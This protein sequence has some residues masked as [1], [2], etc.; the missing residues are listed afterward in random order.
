MCYKLKIFD[1]FFSELKSSIQNKAIELETAGVPITEKVI[2]RLLNRFEKIHSEVCDSRLEFIKTQTALAEVKAKDEELDDLGDGYKVIDYENLKTELQTISSNIDSKNEELEKLRMR[3]NSNVE[4]S[5]EYQKNRENFEKKIEHVRKVYDEKKSEEQ[6]MQWELNNLRKQKDLMRHEYEKL[7]QKSQ[8]LI[9]TPLLR[10]YD[11]I[12]DELENIDRE[13]EK[14]EGKCSQITREIEDIE[15]K[16]DN[17]K[18]QEKGPKDI[19]MKA[20]N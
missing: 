3:Y 18:S 6:Q 12:S 15:I 17:L 2:L 20:R 11:N 7:L 1:F 14:F 13:I 10:N 9:K 19:V 5:K 16:I 4:K 8:L